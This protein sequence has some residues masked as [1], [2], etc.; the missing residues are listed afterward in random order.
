MN[1]FTKLVFIHEYCNGHRKQQT[2]LCCKHNH[3]LH[4]AKRTTS[5]PF[6]FVRRCRGSFL[7][8][9]YFCRQS[10]RFEFLLHKTRQANVGGA[11]PVSLPNPSA[12][13]FA[14][15]GHRFLVAATCQVNCKRKTQKDISPNVS[16]G[17]HVF[18]LLDFCF[19]LRR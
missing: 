16:L 17:V 6:S 2:S 4:T 11:L 18:L 14:L 13:L 9:G 3:S 1:F 10:G 7:C 12:F 19:C 15:Y 8:W 5:Q